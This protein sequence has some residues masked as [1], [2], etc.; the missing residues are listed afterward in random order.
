M[1]RKPVVTAEPSL[2]KPYPGGSLDVSCKGEGMESGYIKLSWSKV[3]SE[4]PENVR[5][6][7]NLI[8]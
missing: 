1:R 7:G 8:R 4:L 3:G 6:R 5:T 2:S